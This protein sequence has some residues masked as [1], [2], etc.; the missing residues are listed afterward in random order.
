MY[1]C[2]RFTSLFD[3]SIGLDVTHMSKPSPPSS[4]IRR[5]R[6]ASS[7]IKRLPFGS[8]T[9]CRGKSRSFNNTLNSTPGAVAGF[10]DG[11][12][13]SHRAVTRAAK[14]AQ[15]APRINRGDG[16]AGNAVVVRA[17]LP[18]VSEKIMFVM[19]RV[20][21]PWPDSLYLN[22]KVYPRS[23]SHNS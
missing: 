6:P 23:A 18:A 11:F 14:N 4:T 20:P 21:R 15:I 17:S 5:T 8:I 10:D 16:M 2:L 22:L 19:K 1:L 9:M 13:P 3:T 12:K 7:T